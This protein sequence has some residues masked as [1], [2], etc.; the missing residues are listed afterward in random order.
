MCWC[1]HEKGDFSNLVRKGYTAFLF[2]IGMVHFQ[3][4]MLLCWIIPDTPTQGCDLPRIST[5]AWNRSEQTCAAVFVKREKD[6]LCF[7]LYIVR[8]AKLVH[9][10]KEKFRLLF[11]KNRCFFPFCLSLASDLQRGHSSVS[12]SYMIWCMWPDAVE[13][14]GIKGGW[15]G[16]EI[17]ISFLGGLCIK[18]RNGG[19]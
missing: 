19:R 13:W 8:A 10:R 18:V 15:A 9:V 6:I 7:I 4:C 5:D 16:R 14:E 1:K 11:S 3:P 2:S 12:P 17:F